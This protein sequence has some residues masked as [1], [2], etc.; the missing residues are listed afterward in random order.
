VLFIVVGVPLVLAGVN[1]LV[2]ATVAID[3]NPSWVTQTILLP[4]AYTKDAVLRPAKRKGA[5]EVTYWNRWGCPA[6][7]AER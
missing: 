3:G 4:V 6:V 2:W 5:G 7:E 1:G